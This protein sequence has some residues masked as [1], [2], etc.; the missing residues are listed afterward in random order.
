MG[1]VELSSSNWE[2]MDGEFVA[3]VART[4]VLRCEEET[5]DRAAGSGGL[6]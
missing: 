1:V 6:M 3:K 5:S 2:N 4:V